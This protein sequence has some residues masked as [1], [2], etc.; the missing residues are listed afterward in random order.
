M[1]AALALCTL[2]RSKDLFSIIEDGNVANSYF[3]RD[4][5][6]SLFTQGSYLASAAAQAVI[7]F[8]DTTPLDGDAYA[9]LAQMMADFLYSR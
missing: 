8:T 9:A 1:R 2:Y 3:S 4:Q 6:A 5:I 7:E